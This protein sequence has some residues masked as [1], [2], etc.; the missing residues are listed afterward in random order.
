MPE[1]MARRFVIVA[2]AL[3]LAPGIARATDWAISGTVKFTVSFEQLSRSSS[4][5]FEGALVLNDDH[6]YEIPRQNML[7][8]SGSGVSLD[9]T[10]T[11]H[12]AR[13]KRIRLVPSN[14]DV[15]GQLASRCLGMSLRIQGQRAWVKL[16]PDGQ[17]LTG[18]SRWSGKV[19][20]QGRVLSF[21]LVQKFNG[22]LYVPTPS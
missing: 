16:D 14:L 7:C 15:L 9:E 10:G 5:A 3:V 20:T 11:W 8:Q 12:V 22:V 2:L 21:S 1:L 6:T 19:A 4:G 18:K 13:R 17:H